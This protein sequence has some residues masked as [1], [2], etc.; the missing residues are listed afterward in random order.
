MLSGCVHQQFSLE[1][2]CDL[3]LYTHLMRKAGQHM[4]ERDTGTD[5]RAAIKP[6][7]VGWQSRLQAILPMAACCRAGFFTTKIFHPNVSKAGEICVNVLKKDWTAEMG[8]KHVLLVV[9][10]CTLLLTHTAVHLRRPAVHVLFLMSL[11]MQAVGS[12]PFVSL[13]RFSDMPYIRGSFGGI[14]KRLC[15]R[16]ELLPSGHLMRVMGGRCGAC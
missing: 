2:D 10:S 12:A 9:R 16:L 5:A 3:L 7:D 4:Q 14:N 11:P 1:R 13:L 6:V 8:L 15:A